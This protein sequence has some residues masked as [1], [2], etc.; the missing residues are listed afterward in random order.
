MSAFNRTILAGA[1]ALSLALTTGCDKEVKP[2]PEAGFISVSVLS[3][4]L[5]A[6]GG[7]AYGDLGGQLELLYESASGANHR[8]SKSFTGLLDIPARVIVANKR[9]YTLS[10]LEIRSAQGKRLARLE[11]ASL[12]RI[13]SHAPRGVLLR[14]L[15]DA[16]DLNAEPELQV[17]FSTQPGGESPVL[18]YRPLTDAFPDP[19]TLLTTTDIEGA[20]ARL[21]EFSSATQAWHEDLLRLVTEAASI[22]LR[23]LS[24]VLSGAYYSFQDR[25]RM[26]LEYSQLLQSPNATQP[27]VQQRLSRLANAIRLADEL[28]VYLNRIVNLG[29]PKAA[30]AT[31]SDALELL[32]TALYPAGSAGDALRLPLLRWPNELTGPILQRLLAL[33]LEKGQPDAGAE[34]A[35][36]WYEKHSDHSTTRLVELAQR[37]RGEHRDALLLACANH[38]SDLSADRA[39]SLAGISGARASEI[40]LALT[41]RLPEI[42]GKA[43]ATV[44]SGIVDASARDAYL[45]EA[46]GLVAA[47]AVDGARAVIAQAGARASEVTVLVLRKVTELDGAKLVEIAGALSTPTLKDQALEDGVRLIA[48]ITLTGAKAIVAASGPRA[49]QIAVLAIARVRDLTGAMLAEIAS[50]AASGPARDSIL[51]SGAS[52]LQQLSAA[53]AVAMLQSA[54]AQRVDLARN[55]LPKV[56]DLT[57]STLADIARVGT[58]G[59][60]RDEILGAGA[61]LLQRVSLAGIKAVL[62]AADAAT[63]E[64]ALALIPKLESA[65]DGFVLADIANVSSD[66]AVRDR[67]L[68]GA[69]SRLQQVS[70]DEAKAVLQSAFAR[71]RELGFSLLRKIAQLNGGRV[72]DLAGVIPSGSIRDAVLMEGVRL[73]AALTTAELVLLLQ[74]ENAAELDLVL[75]GLEKTS[76]LSVENAIRVTDSLS[77][78]SRDPFLSRAVELVT[79]LTAN[80]LLPLADRAFTPAG[81]EEVIR[82]GLAKLGGGGGTDPSV[83]TSTTTL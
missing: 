77:G 21:R 33:A 32:S 7:D 46:V 29:L 70:V 15:V 12:N 6:D 58:N 4:S 14:V 47:F 73:L 71:K 23:H 41:R 69:L 37:F 56:R 24:L 66:G 53:G 61:P 2:V 72:A 8:A 57:G 19:R 17:V 11:D 62:S 79:D 64:L 20:G 55:I 35:A 36:R 28:G 30:D 25:S 51:L 38:V 80:N 54:Y 27:E 39:R 67:I 26:Y 10:V 74:A 52:S 75:L 83:A 43:L 31:L 42:S 18:T 49:V 65:L 16:A 59:Q 50:A 48:V 81:R 68:E 45:I 78:P 1:A 3:K 76:D 82:K 5:G 63:S 60:E 40:A 22:D 9:T 34:I 44:A 13:L